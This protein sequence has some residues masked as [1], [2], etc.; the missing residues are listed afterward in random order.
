[1]NAKPETV[2]EYKNWL[3]TTHDISVGERYKVYY[4][5]VA[6]KVETDFSKSDF[7]V[8]LLDTLGDYDQEY[9]VKQGYQLFTPK[10]SPEVLT[11]PYQSF[12]LKTFR[13]NILENEHWPSEPSG[14]WFLPSNWLSRTNDIVRTLFIVK[15]L[16]GVDFLRSKIEALCKE[17]AMPYEAYF[18]A[19][20]EGYYAVHLYVRRSFEIPK[21]DW[22]TEIVDFS[23]EIQ[24]TTQLQEVIRTLLHKYYDQRRKLIVKSKDKWQWNYRS[25]EFCTNYLGHILH[26]VEGM[27]MDIR[28]KQKGHVDEGR[29]S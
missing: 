18:E 6:S 14:G 15:Y 10:F 7:W 21:F 2:N 1:M 11:K 17:K 9:Q 26:Y 27:I 13:K 24:I 19:R 29:I 20:E 23:V 25:E 12:L 5:S 3:K 4:D 8:Q 28:E 22:D 16:D